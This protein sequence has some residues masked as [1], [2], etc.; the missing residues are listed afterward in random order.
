MKRVMLFLDDDTGEK[1]VRKAKRD[2]RSVKAT[3][4]KIVTDAVRSDGFTDD[5]YMRLKNS[6][7]R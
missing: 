4:E 1:L 2:Y 6:M 3:A 5:E 7:E